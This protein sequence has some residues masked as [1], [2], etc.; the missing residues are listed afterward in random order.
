MTILNSGSNSI[1]KFSYQV[2]KK[3]VYILKFANTQENNSYISEDKSP[4]QQIYSI[5]PYKDPT[6]ENVQS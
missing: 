5:A 2:Q 1:Q 6:Y 4:F 3:I